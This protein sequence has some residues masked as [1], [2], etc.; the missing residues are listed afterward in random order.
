MALSIFIVVSLIGLYLFATAA[1]R[2][3]HE[4]HD[5]L[6]RV[7]E[8]HLSPKVALESGI[9]IGRSRLRLGDEASSLGLLSDA[10]R[11]R[12]NRID[13]L[14]TGG[15]VV[16]AALTALL[17]GLPADSALVALAVA[18]A[19]RH[20]QRR[21]SRRSRKE[22]YVSELVFHLPLVMERIVMAV[23]SGHDV[24]SAIRTVLDLEVQGARSGDWGRDPV[25]RL[26]EVAFRLTEAGVPFDEALQE[27]STAVDCAPLRHAF[28]HLGRAYREGGEIILP[29]RELSDSTQLFYQ[30]TVDE[31]IAKLPVK[32][33]LPLLCTFFGLIVCFVTIPVLQVITT[34]QNARVSTGLE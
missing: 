12:D 14:V 4:V 27:V 23:T 13:R 16:G 7:V 21:V 1:Q 26:L 30:E 3:A 20:I 9:M 33:T 28:I 29:L 2:S 18:G 8:E 34:T 32:A 10:E 17:I 5:D 11:A 22:R 25:C 6:Q 31:R 19:G 15:V 24:L